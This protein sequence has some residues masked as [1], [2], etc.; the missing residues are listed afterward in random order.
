[1]KPLYHKLLATLAL[2]GAAGAAFAVPTVSNVSMQRQ[3]GTRNWEI[4]YDLAD[5]PAIITLEILTNGVPLPAAS[6]VWIT[7]DA[8]KLIE[9]GEGRTI[10][11]N[12]GADWPEHEVAAA[13]PRITAWV[14]NAPPL[15]CAVDLMP[16][17]FTDVTAPVYYYASAEAVPGGVTNILYKTSMLLMRRIDPTPAEGFLMFSQI[18][19][20]GMYY[21]DRQRQTWL[22]RPY[23]IGVYETTQLQWNLV[24]GSIADLGWPSHFTNQVYRLARPVECVSYRHIR[25][26]NNNTNDPDVKWPQ[27]SHVSAGSFMG[28]LRSR[29]NRT[30]FDLPTETQ[31]EYAC[32]A[33]TVGALNDGTMNVKSEGSDPNLNRL[34]RTYYNS[35]GSSS[36][37][38]HCDPTNGTAIVGSYPPNAWGLYDMHGNVSEWCLDY[39]AATANLMGECEDPKGVTTGSSRIMRGGGW[40]FSAPTSFRSAY[41]SGVNPY[42]ND[43]YTGFRVVLNVP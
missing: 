35:G 28:R 13:V 15:Y 27:N 17:R 16:C 6:V 39:S 11:W 42:M 8:S 9:P 38:R 30:G 25:E 10:V 24:M 40:S 37:P 29:T 21:A 7:G 22:T 31:W 41:R 26:K 14:T 5:E 12:A 32:R 4:R 2:A 20:V 34:G 43:V 23:Y 36:S 3:A 1:M 18:N 19:E 33:G